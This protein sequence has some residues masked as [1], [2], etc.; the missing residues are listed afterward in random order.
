MFMFIII[1]MLII[2]NF[3]RYT[4]AGAGAA[5]QEI[6]DEAVSLQLCENCQHTV[7]RMRRKKD[8]TVV[9]ETVTSI[10]RA[11]RVLM[12]VKNY[13]TRK[14]VVVAGLNALIFF[15]INGTLNK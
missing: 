9:S 1:I 7:D 12:F 3:L 15:A 6:D 2:L 11:V 13:P 4:A 10:E 14:G 8:T 5:K